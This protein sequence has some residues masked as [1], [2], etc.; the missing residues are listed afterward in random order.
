M[1]DFV[2]LWIVAATAVAACGDDDPGG[3]DPDGGSDGAV[4]DAAPATDAGPM[5]AEEVDEEGGTVELEGELTLEIPPGAVDGATMITVAVSSE[6]PPEDAAG[7]VYEFGPEGLV[8]AHPVTITLALPDG[9]SDGDVYWSRADGSGGYDNVGGE[10]DGDVIS[11]QVVHFSSGYVGAAEDSRTVTGSQV[12]TWVSAA[13]AAENVPVDLTN[14][15]VAA[16][17]DDGL[18]GYTTIEGVGNDNGTF[19]IEGVPDGEYWLRVPGQSYGAAHYRTSA[20]AVDAGYTKQGRP[21][22]DAYTMPTDLVLNLTNLAPWQ[23]GDQIEMFSSENYSWYFET[24]NYAGNGPAASDQALTDYT[25]DLAIDFAGTP[26]VIDQAAGDRFVVAQLATRLT[27]DATPVSYLAMSRLFEPPP[28]TVTDG[29]TIT[30]DGAFTDVSVSNTLTLDV[31]MDA[32][33]TAMTEET[34]PCD[35][36]PDWPVGWIVYVLGIP[37][38]LEHGYTGATADFLGLALDRGAPNFVATDMGYGVPLTGTW[39][40]H[41]EARFNDPCMYSL[42]ATTTPVVYGSVGMTVAEPVATMGAMPL[43]PRL[44]Q[45]LAPTI[46]SLDL[47]AEQTGFGT[48]PTIAWTAPAVGTP[49]FYE[50]GIVRL[51]VDGDT[52]LRENI[53]TF[54]TADTSLTVPDGVMSAGEAYVIAISAGMTGR[55]DPSAFNREVLPEHR[56]RVQSVIQRP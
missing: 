20:S 54:V 55:T 25:T 43:E 22:A 50:V 44:S 23:D 40:V 16:L 1:R 3:G 31:R 45:V 10:V 35:I 39:G 27:D 46:D 11:T 21:D 12:E 15:V 48:T 51:Y 36:P 28:F 18:G 8:F 34:R 14:F 9:V 6:P 13:R 32:F 33:R 53:A 37:G 29:Q 5:V 2:V 52:T 47:Y 38:G 30:L 41:G 7:P 42:P 49:A 24:E 56:S 4:L 26:H 17:V 19:T